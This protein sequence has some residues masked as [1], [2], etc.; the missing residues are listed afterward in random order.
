MFGVPAADPVVC[1]GFAFVGGALV[2][3]VL[4]GVDEV[5]VDVVGEW[6]GVGA[7]DVEVAW[8]LPAAEC[9]ELVL[10][11]AAELVGCDVFALSAGG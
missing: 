3:C 6:F 4:S 8:S 2:A 5:D 1:L 9:V 11:V 7:D 10:M